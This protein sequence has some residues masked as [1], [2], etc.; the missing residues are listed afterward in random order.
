M[1]YAYRMGGELGLKFKTQL[2]AQINTEF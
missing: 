1:Y 2:H